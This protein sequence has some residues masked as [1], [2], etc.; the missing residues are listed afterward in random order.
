MM[1]DNTDLL[2]AAARDRS[3]R[4]RQRAETTLAALQADRARVSVAEFCRQAGISRGWLYTQPD[5]LDRLHRDNA[6]QTRSDRRDGGSPASSDSLRRRLQLAHRHIGKLTA[7]NR[8][9]RDELALAYGQL[10]QL[11]ASDPGG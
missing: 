3:E 4:T 6:E 10:R 8:D 2:R 11:R 5:I 1:A 7:D 9:L